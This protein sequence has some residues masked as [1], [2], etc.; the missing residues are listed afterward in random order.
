M[1][2][3][4]YDKLFIPPQE[5][6][7]KI[8]GLHFVKAVITMLGYFNKTSKIRYIYTTRVSKASK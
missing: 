2:E 5:T 8:T 1:S 3:E 4:I 7:N 6:H